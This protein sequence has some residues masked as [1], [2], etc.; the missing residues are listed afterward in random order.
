MRIGTVIATLLLIFGQSA[1]AESYSGSITINGW[2]I[3]LPP[4]EWTTVGTSDA[5]STPR[6]TGAATALGGRR[7]LLAQESGG[8]L[9]GLVSIFAGERGESVVYRDWQVM[10][11]AA[12]NVSLGVI[13]REGNDRYQNCADVRTWAAT[14]ARPQN[15]DPRWARYF[16]M[17]QARPGWAPTIF[18]TAWSR[19]ADRA[20]AVNVIYHFS[21]ET[22]GFARDSKPW[23]QNGWNPANQD[24]AQKAYVERLV[25]W[26]RETH[27]L[28]R[29]GYLYGST[30]PAPAF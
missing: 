4:G 25:A 9:T 29:R 8:R 20:G 18:H 7:V 24:A 1:L 12:T 23:P 13:V 19:M 21:P 17:A 28:V 14:T 16:D 15:V 3:P 30:T 22:R 10:A 11:C 6:M 2:A 27:A 26:L 5:P